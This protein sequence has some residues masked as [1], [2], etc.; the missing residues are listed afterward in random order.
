[1]FCCC[2]A[3]ATNADAMLMLMLMLTRGRKKGEGVRSVTQT[4]QA[5]VKGR[6]LS[7]AP[8]SRSSVDWIGLGVS[9]QA[10]NGAHGRSLKLKAGEQRNGIGQDRWTEGCRFELKK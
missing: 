9:Q 5:N 3:D 4:D 1:M 2:F 10:E 7:A 8:I 6:F